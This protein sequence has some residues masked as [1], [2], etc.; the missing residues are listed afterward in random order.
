LLLDIGGLDSSA[1]QPTA[2]LERLIESK[3]V[4]GAPR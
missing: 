4:P 2:D 3:D 1:P